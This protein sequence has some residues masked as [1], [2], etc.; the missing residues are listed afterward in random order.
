MKFQQIGQVLSQT[1]FKPEYGILG[2]FSLPKMVDGPSGKVAL[3]VAGPSN[4]P[5]TNHKSSDRTPFD[6]LTIWVRTAPV[7]RAFC[8]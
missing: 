6:D 8:I 3:R 2:S 4:I 7:G 5:N 1:R